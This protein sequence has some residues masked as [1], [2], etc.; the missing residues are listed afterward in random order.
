MMNT[1]FRAVISA[2]AGICL[3]SAM[4]SAC[5]QT[6][7]SRAPGQNTGTRLQ[8]TQRQDFQRSLVNATTNWGPGVTN[9]TNVIG[10]MGTTLGN[11]PGTMLGMNQR[12]DYYG[13]NIN[14]GTN[15]GTNLGANP[16]INTRTNYG[17]T[18]G[19]NFYQGTNLGTNPRVNMGLNQGTRQTAFDVKKANTIK[20]QLRGLAGVSDANVLVM[21]NTALV[22]YKPKGTAANTTAVKNSIIR[23]CKQADPS[24][25]NVTV[26][27]SPDIMTRMTRLG[28]SITG[29]RPVNAIA[30]EFRR[31][32][33]GITPVTR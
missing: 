18:P 12:P 32:I 2:A 33:S 20:R 3:A 15:F 8:V 31:M 28:T 7:T 24:I 5:A 23:R 30:D 21:G 19:T 9:R 27:E 6:G 4:L 11:Y 29:N 14:P 25:T 10:N 16:G 17:T 13:T 22:G 1:N 26:S